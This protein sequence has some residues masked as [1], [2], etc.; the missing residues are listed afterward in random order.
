M[1]TGHI[2]KTVDGVGVISSILNDYI[3]VAYDPRLYPEPISGERTR[4]DHQVLVRYAKTDWD[5]ILR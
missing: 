3:V 4:T 1:I 2:V 5:K